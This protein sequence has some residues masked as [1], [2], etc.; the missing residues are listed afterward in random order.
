MGG[1]LFL[2]NSGLGSIVILVGPFLLIWV[3]I[4]LVF[5]PSGIILNGRP[6]F[7]AV[8]ESVRIV[9]ANLPATLIFLLAV[10]LISTLVDWLL[11]MADGGTW[12]TLVNI[13][14]HAFISTALL[15]AIFIFYR[16]RYHQQFGLESLANN[17]TIPEN[18]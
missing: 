11:I 5:A 9:Q 6:V 12:L 17:Q 8:V 7:R 3:V 13:L 2:I 10:L 4:Y 15:A 1:I 16:D 18:H 14:A